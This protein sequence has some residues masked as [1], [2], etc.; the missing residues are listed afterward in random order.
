VSSATTSQR[1]APYVPRLVIEWLSEGGGA[2]RSVTGTLAF[3]DISGF[4]ALTERLARRGKVGAEEI[5]DVLNTVFEQL[6]AAAYDYGASL[7]KFGGD[8]VLLL[9]EDDEHAAMAA[10]ACVEMQRT[11]RRMGP[12]QTSAGT[13][14]LKMSIGIHSADFDVFLVGSS[15]HELVVS[16]PGATVTALMEKTA[17]AGEIVMSRASAELLAAHSPRVVGPP[18]GDGFQLRSAPD[19][20][21]SPNRKPK[22][23][24]GVDLQS[25]MCANL[26][27]HLRDHLAEGEHRHVSIAF[28]QVEGV[29][30]LLAD[31][32]PSAAADAL[33]EIVSR[34]QLEA[35]AQ[36]VTFLGADLNPDGT[37]LILVSG[38]PTAT[39]D[40]AARLLS[41]TR[42]IVAAGGKLAV[43]AGV[44]C[45]RVFAGDYGPFYR[46]TYSVVGDDVNLAARVMAAARPGQ[47]LA[48][49]AVLKR[50]RTSFATEAVP[51]FRVKG[52]SEP[53]TARIVGAPLGSPVAALGRPL[54]LV[55]RE[56]ELGVL[57]AGYDSA[58]RGRGTVI[59]V[60]GDPGLGKSRLVA[61][62]EDVAGA[63]VLWAYGD[64]YSASTPYLPMQRLL[65]EQLSL[66]RDPDAAELGRL[67]RHLVGTRAPDL[68]PWMPLVGIVAGVEL[69]STPEIDLVDERFRRGQLERVTSAVL[70][71]LLTTPT[72]LVFDDT[73]FMDEA[74]IEL[75]QQLAS[76][77]VDRP[78]LIIATRRGGPDS[79]DVLRGDVTRVVLS[80][81]DGAAAREIIHATTEDSTPMSPH[82]QTT[83]VELA[84]GN[85]MFLREL[86]AEQLS[87]GDTASLPDSVEGVI[88]ARIDRLA[89]AQRALLRAAAVMGRRVEQTQLAQVLAG[90][91][92]VR[93][94]LDFGPLA[95]FLSRD[96]DG[97]LSFAHNVVRET[98]YEGLS[99]RRRVILH[100]RAGDLIERDAGEHAHLQADVLSMHFLA[101]ERF[102]AAWQYS[103]AAGRR[104]LA[105]YAVADAAEFLERALTAARHL[106]ETPAP[107]LAAVL[108]MLGD[109][110]YRLGDLD[111][112][113]SAYDGARRRFADADAGLDQARLMLKTATV[114]ERRGGY[115]QALAWI[116][117]GRLLLQGNDSSVEDRLRAEMAAR[118][119]RI[120][121][122]Q[123]HH[124][125]A[126]RWAQDA[127]ELAES[128]GDLA[129]LR[130]AWS[131]STGP[132]PPWGGSTAL[133]AALAP[134]R[135]T[136]SSVT[137][138]P[139]AAP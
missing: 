38:A 94:G 92:I 60:V 16:G 93:E 102:H 15:H 81:L 121:Y 103:H 8:A 95:E 40:D 19:V 113:R 25:A 56:A 65:R 130:G 126:L 53:V 30:S 123:G 132:A 111:K 33:Q 35:Q 82:R 62:L 124:Q 37:K 71:A 129:T 136:P 31:A 50:S 106:P 104:A 120:R 36:G 78:W 20:A 118:V 14:R 139:R 134:C 70:G 84:A 64:V 87:R 43:R 69:P 63:D 44:H 1:L 100:G 110:R 24:E 117:R 21:L 54:P 96:E 23:L 76:D 138:S 107:Q 97:A 116:T 55:G 67:L 52:K 6:L 73:Q 114:V 46:R 79:P 125:A 128:C 86:V 101:A 90:D 57:L 127:I 7:L 17:R 83:I 11:L 47:V 27:A 135:S 89:P 74:T 13:A 5:G 85:P 133:P 98:A 59:E 32:G 109:V 122:V 61:E 39:G 119:A 91:T 41:A 80:P 29:D 42:A 9:F 45:G 112:A 137:S 105:Q 34:A 115:Q 3:V 58:A 77:A 2:H 49:E 10:R 26:A 99:Y 51:A 72:V 108:E 88:A 75:I 12:L 28:L 48:T 66:G 131:T 22:V 4:T 68:L 18:R